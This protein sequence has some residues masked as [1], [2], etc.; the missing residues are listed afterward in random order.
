MVAA[1]SMPASRSPLSAVNLTAL[2]ERTA[3]RPEVIVG[4][5]DGS[6]AATHPDIATQSIRI[7]SQASDRAQPRA[8]GAA[9]THGTFVAGILAATRGFC[10][11]G[12]LS[13]LH[14]RGAVHFSPALRRE[15]RYAEREPAGACG[16]SHRVRRPS[17]CLVRLSSD[18][19]AARELVNA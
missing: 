9:L 7:L 5:I 12:D 19:E 14:P 2:M 6:V 1:A 18:A 4:L 15:C 13:R 8:N 3:G 16:R 11:A 17:R 10:G